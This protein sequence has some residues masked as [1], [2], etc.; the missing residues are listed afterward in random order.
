VLAGWIE[1]LV[2]YKRIYLGKEVKND[3]LGLREALFEEGGVKIY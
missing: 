1:A 2:I 3:G